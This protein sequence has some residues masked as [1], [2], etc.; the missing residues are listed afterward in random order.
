MRTHI[1]VNQHVI[2]KNAKTGERSPP[3]TVKTYKSNTL[4]HSVAIAGPCK[5][6][7]QPDCPLSCGA[8]VWIETDAAVVIDP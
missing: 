5:V 7:Y 6:V 3:L 2:R 1:H 4:A 8:R